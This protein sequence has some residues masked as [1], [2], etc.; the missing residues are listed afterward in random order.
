MVSSALR[1]HPLWVA[2]AVLLFLGLTLLSAYRRVPWNDEGWFAS[3]S[4]TLLNHGYM[5]T[6][7]IE[8]TGTHLPKPPLGL[9]RYTYW[10]L[11]LYLLVQTCWYAVAGVGLFTARLPS[12]FWG[13]IGLWTFYSFTRLF[14]RDEAI[15]RL[16]VCL[17]AIDTLYINDAAMARMDM[18]AAALSFL[19]IYLYMLLRETSYRWA[20]LASYTMAAA[21]CMTHHQA[22][23]GVFALLA[24]TLFLDRRRLSWRLIAVAALPIL[25]MSAGWLWYASQ[26]PDYFFAQIASN[27]SGRLGGYRQPWEAI[28]AEI[29][30]RYDFYG[31]APGS[32]PFRKILIV[33]PLTFYASLILA[34]IRHSFRKRP[35]LNLVVAILVV[36]I[37][38]QV[39]LEGNKLH[40]YLVHV[41]PWF[42]LLIAAE[43]IT[44]W[45]ENPK[46]RGVLIVFLAVFGFIQ[47]LSSAMVIRNHDYP[48][49]IRPVEQAIAAAAGNR[50]EALVNG[51]PE[52][53]FY[54]GFD[55]LIDDLRLGYYSHRTPSVV[56]VDA[57]YREFFATFRKEEP[58]VSRYIQDLLG[59][60]RPLYNDGDYEVYEIP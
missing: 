53:G 37:V 28:K 31:Y 51:S 44:F 19:A 21:A 9:D 14:L 24:I 13:L 40:L 56:V 3:A 54:I 23:L 49:T 34:A 39:L 32:N 35:E 30:R 1:V 48:R 22:I 25:V 52:L 46:L 27:G 11:P 45:R 55:S 12:V 47:G 10:V 58:A 6:K 17:L 20:I 8:P 7:V 26:R 41:I 36:Q 2:S 33:I 43:W 50:S 16:T 18:M 60:S 5:G 15:A 29:W 38:F 59:R 42:M 57:R 4:A